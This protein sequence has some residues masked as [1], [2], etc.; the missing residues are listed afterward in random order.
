MVTFDNTS[1]EIVQ[2]KS[3]KENCFKDSYSKKRIDTSWDFIKVNTKEYTHCFHQYPA[4]MIPQVARRIIEEYGYKSNLLFDPYC[5]TGTSL[6]EA[7][8]LGINAIGTDLNPLARLIAT[9]KTN[10]ICIDELNRIINIFEDYLFTV[11][12]QNNHIQS[13]I[14]PNVK[15]IDYWF[16]KEVQKKLGIILGFIEDIVDLSIRNFFKVA[17][18]E[19]VRN[20]S[21]LKQGEFKIIRSKQYEERNDLDVFSI[22]ISKLCRNKKGLED[23]INKCKKDTYSLIY[24]FDTVRCIPESII[25]PSSVDI[26]VSSP[27]YG[28]S[29]T[30]VAYG[31]YSRFA[32]EWLGF[33]EANQVDNILMG[34]KKRKES[35]DFTS[36][37]LTSVIDR[38][39]D[40][41]E[42]RAKDVI[43][44]YHDYENSIANV[45]TTIKKKG[46]V[47]YVV[48][49][50]TV[51]GINIPNDEIT[52]QLFQ[53]NGFNHIETIV[54]NIPNKRMPSKNSPSNKVGKSGA[55]MK[56]EYIVICQKD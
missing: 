17:F 54:R 47:C 50:R 36:E 35:Y 8:L 33:K 20:V 12:F 52:V 5:G 48:G 23:F 1:M 29:R 37:T 27:P 6:V 25:Q 38:I 28:D 11:G 42:S 9:A 31:Q 26:V 39:V 7:N 51:K 19:T 34:G 10:K 49:N 3:S 24:D 16:S 30:T 13:I 2:I 32:N 44:F 45:A 4:M 46:F 21:N 56:N 43:S 41:D 15:N 14:I 22:M 40:E 18:S 55:T 53:Q